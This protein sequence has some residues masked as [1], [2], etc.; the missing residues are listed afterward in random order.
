MR[1]DWLR[2]WAKIERRLFTVYI[3]PIL[4]IGCLLTGCTAASDDEAP[5]SAVEILVGFGIGGGTDL[6][7]RTLSVGLSDDLGV[8]VK[9]I[10]ITGGSGVGAFRELMRRPVDGCTLLALTSD[11]VVLDVLQ[12]KDVDLDRLAPLAR[13]HTE[14]GLLSTRTEGAENWQD[15]IT[16]VKAQDRRLLIGGVGA[17][18]FDRTAVNI[19][20]SNAKVPFRYIPY[21]GTKEMHADLFGGRLD[22]IYDEFGVMQP[23]FEANEARP[24]MTLSEAPEGL[25]TDTPSSTSLGLNAAPPIWR[26]TVMHADTPAADVARY[27]AAIQRA[28]QTDTYKNY[29]TGRRLNLMQGQLDAEG[30]KAALARDRIDFSAVLK[31][32]GG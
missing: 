24:L 23:I 5:C 10:N 3:R 25:L 13:A 21:N 29:E 30:F 18:S 16:D 2:S 12:P 32:K 19:T 26:G 17:R 9:V 8:P 4:I 20:L 11:Y 27:A 1:W 6:F 22:A 15:L 14:L 28:M 7:S 31:R